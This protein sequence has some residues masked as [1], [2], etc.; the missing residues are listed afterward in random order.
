MPYFSYITAANATIYAFPRDSFFLVLRT[1]FFLS[2]WLLSRI[3]IVLKI[4]PKRG[5]ITFDPLFSN[6]VHYGDGVMADRGFLI[7]DL[8]ARHYATLNIPLF[9]MEKETSDRA[10]TKTR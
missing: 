4:W 3:T 6:T 8:V 9:A 10:V 5:L 7:Y 2:H 1:I